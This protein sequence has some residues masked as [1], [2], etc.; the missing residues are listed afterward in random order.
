MKPDDYTMEL[1]PMGPIGEGA[2]L[3]LRVNR[4]C[5]W[6]QCLFCSV[7]KQSRFSARSVEEI[8]GDIDTARRIG[9]LL[10]GK[11]REMGL[12]GWI[13]QEVIEKVIREQPEIFGDY[14]TRVTQEQR[15]ALRC[16]SNVAGWY[17]Y[18][19]RRVFLQDANALFLKAGDLV[20]V[21]RYLKG[22]FPTVDTVTCYARAKTCAQRT[23]EELKELHEAG[24]SWCLVGIES[25][26]DRVLDSMKK[27]ATKGDHISGGQKLMASGIKMA[28]FVMPGLAGGDREMSARHI[29]D[30]LDVLNEIRPTEIRV[31]SLAVLESA[32]LRGKWEAGE[33]L[34]PSEEQMVDELKGLI[35]GVNFD[36]TFETLQMTNLF[37]F[38]GQLPARRNTFLD[39]ISDYQALS[40]LERA[41]YLL[42]RYIHGGYL[43]F[44]QSWD[45]PDPTLQKKIGEAEKSLEEESPE[46]LGKVE[47]VLWA[48]KSKGIP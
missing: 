8:K 35:E 27:G 37:T 20:E 30:T 10:E 7:Y 40:P 17:M 29:L 6:N 23:P 36:C 31:R 42:N 11:S 39:A 34:P 1:G 4:N 2:A 16:L 25:G 19:A 44:V 48:V 33:F 9:D 12:N 41:R 21:L 13:Q 32:P 26:C 24:L 18:G 3:M 5:P 46:A 45:C 43:D 15:R 14:P 22:A 47:R 28:A 38:K